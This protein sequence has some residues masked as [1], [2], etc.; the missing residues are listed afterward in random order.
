[1]SPDH[2]L[3]ACQRVLSMTASPNPACAKRSNVE[4]DICFLYNI[5]A[6]EHIKQGFLLPYKGLPAD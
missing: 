2:R 5:R 3:M 1:V 6:L 4:G